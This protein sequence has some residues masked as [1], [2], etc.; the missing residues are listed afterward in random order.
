M[1]SLYD[2]ACAMTQAPSVRIAAS[3]VAHA[4]FRMSEARWSGLPERLREAR[5]NAA[6]TQ[7]QLAVKAGVGSRTVPQYETEIPPRG[8]DR[9]VVEKLAV[10]LGVDALW[11]EFGSAPI[12]RDDTKGVPTVEGWLAMEAAAGRAVEPEL[13]AHL[14]RFYARTGDIELEDV[15]ALVR[16]WRA[17]QADRRVIERPALE[18]KIDESTS[19]EGPARTGARP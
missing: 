6:L 14:R 16:S 8:P 7:A 1:D 3:A 12:H 11:L 17:R 10:A 18:T 4:R 15:L 5:K 13:V 9:S 2:S 19:R